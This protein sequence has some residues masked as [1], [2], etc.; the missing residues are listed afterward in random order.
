MFTTS[1][2]I[3]NLSQSEVLEYKKLCRS[4]KITK[5]SD[6][7]KLDIALIA[8]EKLEII[9]KNADNEYSCSTDSNHILAKIRCSSKGYCFAVRGKNQEDIYIKENLLNHSWNGDKVLVRIIK[10]GYKRRSPEGI[11]DCIL[12]RTNQILLSKVE[13]I[14]NDI[15][16]I[17]ID[18]RILS[19]IKLPKDDKKYIYKSENKNIVKVEIDRFPIGEEEGLGHVIK[20]LQLNNNEELDTDFVLSKSNINKLS[21]DNLIE[22]KKIEERERID[23]S[24]KNSYLLK[25]WNSD[26][27]PMLPL[28]QVEQGKNAST[29]L[30]LHTNNLAERID[31]SSKKSLEKFFNS[32][33]SLPLLSNWQNY[34]S[35]GIR[36]V[37]E[38]KQGEKIQAISLCLHLNSD[39]EITDWSFHLT[40]V[41][42]S[43]IIGS[44]HTDALLSRKSKTRI[45]SR[46]LKPLK[47][48]IEDLDK[49]LEISTSFRQRHLS[50][51]KIEIPSQINKIESLDEFFIHN[52]ADYSKGYFEPLKKEDCQTYLSP[53]IYEANLIWF[54]HSNQY[55][56]K[57]A[58][59]F[60]KG[61]DYINAN[62]II[63]YS[64]LVDNNIELNEDG[65]LSFSQVINMCSD[66]NKKRILYKLLINEFK[67]NEVSLISKNADSDES[68]KLFISPWTLPEY[69][70]T[71]LMNQ[72]CIFN[73]IVSGKKSKKNNINELNIMESNS[74]NLVDWDIFNSSIKRN[75]ETLFNK[76]VIDKL[77]EYKNKVTQYKY[78]MISIKKVRKA[79]KL[80]GNTYSGLI[81]SVQSYGFFVEISEL[82][83]EGLVHVSTL[84]NDWYEYRSR[85]NL[86]IGRKSK[87][88]YKVGDEIEVKIIKVDILKYQIDLELT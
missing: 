69:D 77:N 21:N 28:I 36:N 39:N 55:G 63:K 56:L 58:G 72:Y 32:F 27:S 26:N 82:N 47:A 85:Q 6:K 75:I 68:E 41:R 16:A 88:S 60:L 23:L 5:K 25:S 13:I 33:E 48:Y 34:L 42:C 52:P 43:L 62:E 29:K 40:L 4:L 49:I 54:K 76:F 83:V 18:D 10:E 73:M 35:K 67:E 30:W 86:L 81:L 8:L 57:S 24:D 71:N 61:L 37:C 65:N 70:F 15:Y 79:E 87:K 80:L 7:D 38:F 20:E 84:N 1:S 74:L 22:Y 14:N 64:E 11:V 9:N 45:S 17:P 19:K 53:I 31:L 59:Y 3:D 12:E 2:I 44:E 50:E 46:I 66:D 78:N 51:G